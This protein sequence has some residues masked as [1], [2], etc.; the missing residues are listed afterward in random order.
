MY[1]HHYR[2]GLLL[3]LQVALLI[4]FT[5]LELPHAGAEYLHGQYSLHV[6]SLLSTDIAGISSLRQNDHGSLGF[7]FHQ[8]TKQARAI[9]NSL[10]YS[11]E[12]ISTR[13]FKP[14]YDN[15]NLEID[16]LQTI[17]DIDDDDA[18]IASGQRYITDIVHT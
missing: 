5:K 15:H 7:G 14:L 6:P 8:S 16:T 18:D 2:G 9:T 11:S 13:S 12:Q 1:L 3:L 10:L 4:I 17:I